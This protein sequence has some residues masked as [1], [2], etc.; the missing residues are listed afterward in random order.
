MKITPVTLLTCLLGATVAFPVSAQMSPPSPEPADMWE[1][2]MEDGSSLYTN[3]ERPGCKHMLLRPLSVVPSL[4]HL[5]TASY[6]SISSSISS[7]AT[8]AAHDDRPLLLDRSLEMERRS[9]PD[10]ARNWYATVTPSESAKSEVC[11]LYSEWLHLAHK[12]RGGLFFGS[13]PS[14]GGDLSAGNQR[15]PSQSFY[16]NARWV[17]LS[18]LFGTGFVPVGCP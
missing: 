14:Y 1:C 3:K 6:P 13:D 11:S 2:P 9:I 8:G 4:E 15:G 7:D 5:P 12:T 16:D 17:T 10:W 18:R